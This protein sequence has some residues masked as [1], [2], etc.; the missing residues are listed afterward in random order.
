MPHEPVAQGQLMCLLGH[1]GDGL[2]CGRGRRRAGTEP[3]LAQEGAQSKRP[4]LSCPEEPEILLRQPEVAGCAPGWEYIDVDGQASDEEI[5]I[6]GNP[7]LAEA[8]GAEPEGSHLGRAT[9]PRKCGCSPRCTDVFECE[10]YGWEQRC[11]YAVE[12]HE[13]ACD[14]YRERFVL[15]RVPDVTPA[16]HCECSGHWPDSVREEC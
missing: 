6:L 15:Q 12:S 10:G 14:R 16:G 4:R 11:R 3:V 7:A 8:E 1:Q 13:A 9:P 5:G 2:V